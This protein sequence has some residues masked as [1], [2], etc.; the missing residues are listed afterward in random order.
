MSGVVRSLSRC[1]LP[2]EATR[3]A[4]GSKDK[5]RE[6]DAVQER[7]A[8]RRSREID[9]MLARERRAVRRLV[10]ILLLGAGES[11]KSTFLKQMRIINGKEFDKKALL[12]FRD[13]IFENIIK[14]MRVLVDLQTDPSLFGCISS[15]LTKPLLQLQTDPSLFGCISSGLT[16]PLLQLQTDPSLFGCISSGLTKPLL[17]LQTDPS[18]FGCISSGL[19]KPLLQLQTDPSLFGCISSGLTKPLLQLQTDPSLFGCISSGLTKPLLQLQTDPS[20][21]GCISSGLTKPLLQLQTDPSL[22]GCISSGLTKPLLQLQTD[23]S[24]FGC[25]SSG[26]TKPLLQLQTDPSLFGCIS[27]GL[28]KPLLQLQTDPS[29]FGCISS[30]LTNPLLQLQTDPSLF[31]ASAANHLLARLLT[32]HQPATTSH[33]TQGNGLTAPPNKEEVD[34]DVTMETSPGSGCSVTM[35]ILKHLESSL[36]SDSHTQVLQGLRLLAL[37]LPKLEAPLRGLVIRRVLRPLEG[38]VLEGRRAVT[39]PLMDV[40]LAT[41]RSGPCDSRLVSLMA[42]MLN[43]QN[44]SDAALCA[45]ATLHPETCPPGL[46]QKVVA[47]LL[48]PLQMVT[49]VTLL[50]G[51]NDRHTDQ[52]TDHRH[53]DRQ[54]DHRHT[55]QQ[56]DHRHT[57]QQTDHRHTD[58]QTDHRHTDGQTDHRQAEKDHRHTG[59]QTDHRH[60]DQ[61][62]DHRHTDQQI[63]NRHTDQQTDHRHTD[64]QTDHRHTDQQTDHRQAE[65]DQDRHTDQQA[66]H[67][68]AEED[69]D[70]QTEGR[71]SLSLL[72]DHLNHKPSCISLLCV[73]VSSAPY[74]TDMESSASVILA[75]VSLLRICNGHSPE[76][77][78]AIGCS[79]ASTNLIGCSKVQRCGLDCLASLSTC[80]GAVERAVEVFRVLVQNLQNP[81]SDPTVLQKTYQAMLRWLSVSAESSSLADLVNEDLLPVLKKRVCD[82]RWEVRDSTLEFLGRL[83]EALRCT[84]T[85]IL[86]EA[87]CDQESYVRATAISALARTLSD[88]QG[89]P[90]NRT[91]E[92][93]L[94]QLLDILSQD[95]EVFPRRAVVQFFISWLKTH[96]SSSSSSSLRSVLS[97]GST[98]LD[99]EV[100]VHTLELVELLMEETLPGHQGSELGS[101]PPSYGGSGGTNLLTH[102]D[103]THP[104]AVTPSQPSPL[105]THTTT[106]THTPPTHPSVVCGLSRLVDLG[107][108]TAL[109][110]GLFD[111]DRPVALKACSLLLRLRDAVCVS[112]SLRKGAMTTDDTTATVATV[113]FDL[114]GQV[115]EREV[116]RKLQEKRGSD[117][118]KESREVACDR[119]NRNRVSDRTDGAGSEACDRSTGKSVCEGSARVCEVLWSLG[120]EERQSVSSQSSDHVQNSPLSLLE[121]ILNATDTSH[122]DEVIVD[123][124]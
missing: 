44:P 53:T 94:G 102:T 36:E 47:V 11:G 118:V 28:T 69:Q 91:Q 30:G 63:E 66:Y 46:R 68:Q 64:G 1:L 90:G 113:T 115:W 58:Q 6:R 8:R 52:Q 42:S 119:P 124:Y 23:P 55:G 84:V 16:K 105:L 31:V 92:E 41:Y 50:D 106:D 86:L 103:L 80:P 40:L 49:G 120:L 122:T 100:K 17:Q 72:L 27:S 116:T 109:L 107:V 114:R 38:L 123:C 67:R 75:V 108:V 10:K 76:S 77:K 54:T 96:P 110:N 111:C 3:E 5:I 70:R 15:G 97:L 82:V 56:T 61:Q 117:W 85:P 59:Q 37:T 24:L 13:T 29:L 104:Y 35:E 121:D 95:S 4:G 9:S 93:T 43:S 26:L 88:Q 57:D 78:A 7:E 73:S 71:S 2:A 89:E 33:T 34:L 60:T 22:F 87:L 51:S 62:A 25:I 112:R 81:D 39:Q 45:A 83:C 19:T 74:I 79:K 98:D 21:F 12:D 14:G 99:W 20:L 18:L 101:A 48:T 32:F 65:E